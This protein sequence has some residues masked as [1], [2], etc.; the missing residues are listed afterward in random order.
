MTEATAPTAAPLLDMQE[1]ADQLRISLASI[2]RLIEKGD[3]RVARIGR[4]VRI[5][6]TE[7]E[8][9]VERSTGDVSE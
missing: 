6:Q 8:A 4:L 2:R 5:S 1:A 7:L 3:L 9:F